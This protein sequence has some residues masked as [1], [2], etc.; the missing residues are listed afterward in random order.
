MTLDPILAASPAI[1]IHLA[2]VTTAIPLGAWLLWVSRKGAPGH[3][4][5]GIAFMVLIVGGAIASLFIRPGETHGAPLAFWLTHLTAVLVPVM[6]WRA[7]S[8]AR[9]G[10]IRVHRHWVSGLFM[11]GLVV[12]LIV[13]L[14]NT[15]GLLHHALFG[16]S[17]NYQAL[18]VE[19]SAHRELQR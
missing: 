7:I 5:V 13:N 19:T 1:R 11:G 8:A 6:A 12:N 15:N 3:R 2:L 17:S 4:A 10:N 14:T 16:P 18:S 9:Q